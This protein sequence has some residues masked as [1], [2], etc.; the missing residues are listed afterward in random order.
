MAPT[1]QRRSSYSRRA[2][3]SLFTGYIAAGAGALV[4]AILLGLSL[5]QPQFL[6]G[7]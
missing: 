5:W 2:Q 1:G 4:G 6:S 7:L 3:Y